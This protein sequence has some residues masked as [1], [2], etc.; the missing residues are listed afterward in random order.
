MF[1][2]THLLETACLLRVCSSHRIYFVDINMLQN[3]RVQNLAIVEAASLE[4]GPGLNVISGETGTGKSILIGALNLILG[5]RADKSFI[6]SGAADAQVEAV[7]TLSDT[8]AIDALLT[9]TGLAPCEDGQVIIRRTIAVAGTGRCLINDAA[10]TVQTLRR[11]GALLVDIHGPYDHQSLLEPQFQLDLLDAFGRCQTARNACAETYRTTR[12]LARQRAELEGSGEGVGAEIE[13]LQF[14]VDEIAG[15]KLTD[16]DEED[17]IRDHATAANAEA[18]LNAGNGLLAALTD[19]DGA[20][21]DVLATSQQRLLELS[22]L[23]PEAAG[24][25]TEAQSAAIQIQELSRAISERLQRI[26]ADAG[27]LQALEERMALVQKLKRKHGHTVAEVLATLTRCQT[28]LTELQSRG[29]RLARLDTEQSAAQAELVARAAALT[30]L[31]QAAAGNLAR[32]ITR[33]LRDLG[34]L[35]AG[36]DVSLTDCEPRA[37]GADIISFGFAPNPGEPMRALRDIASSGEIARVMLAV[38]AVLAKHDRIPVLVFDE[39]DANIGGEVGRAVGM[40]LRAV[41]VTHQVI[42]ITH[43]PQVAVYGQQHHVVTKIVQK[44]RTTT[45]IAC[46]TGEARAGEIARML[47]GKDLTP[48]TLDHARQMLAAAE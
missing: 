1:H 2:G 23:L 16:A 22:R 15:A 48:V 3:L 4:L 6:R 7:F 36:F 9:E 26:D 46:V 34:F 12:D 37:D 14:I 13:R 33:E 41:A 42:C 32:A 43:L 45:R 30:K 31:R 27:R 38:K 29:E 24:W 35:K 21:F 8:R 17:L 40:K 11:L 19:G 28:R 44:N 47:G 25:R 5:D 20:V 10:V 18:I 39:I